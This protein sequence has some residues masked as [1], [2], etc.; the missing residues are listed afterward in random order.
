MNILIE[1]Q[2]KINKKCKI[3][4]YRKNKFKEKTYNNT[5]LLNNCI[6]SGIDQYNDDICSVSVNITYSDYFKIKGE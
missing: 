5:Y 6:V 4:K 2:S 1:E 3:F